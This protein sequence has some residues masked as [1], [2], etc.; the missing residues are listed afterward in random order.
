M[1]VVDVI[2]HYQRSI[3]KCQGNH[4][5]MLHCISK[6]YRLPVTV[7]HLQDTGIG[8]T[9]NN[10]RKYEGDT[11]EAAKALVAKW[12]AMVA[13]EDSSEGEEQEEE[14]HQN[15][16]E[17]EDTSLK[18]DDHRSS[19]K[20][21]YNDKE[22]SQYKE[23]THDDR[24]RSHHERDRSHHTE[25]SQH[26]EKSHHDRDRSHYEKEKSH[27]SKK[28]ID[29]RSKK[30]SS[31]EQSR[32]RKHEEENGKKYEKRRHKQMTESESSESEENSTV[33]EEDG[34]E[35]D[36]EVHST[37]QASLNIDDNS[38]EEEPEPPK[39]KNHISTKEHSRSHSSSSSSNNKEHSSNKEHRNSK[40]HGNNKQQNSHRQDKDRSKHKT[41]ISDR[42][43][44]KRKEES[45]KKQKLSSD[46]PE[47]KQPTVKI[48]K[49]KT[50]NEDDM[51][52]KQHISSSSPSTSS[53]S[54]SSKS[55]S[56]TKKKDVSA[57][58]SPKEHCSEAT[59]TAVLC[60]QKHRSMS[61]QEGSIKCRKQNCLSQEEHFMNACIKQSSETQISN[62]IESLDDDMRY[63]PSKSTRRRDSFA[64]YGKQLESDFVVSASVAL[65]TLQTDLKKY[66]FI[67]VLSGSN[68]YF[69]NNSMR[70][71]DMKLEPLDVDLD[72]TLPPITPNYKP[73]P[74]YNLLD[75]P[76]HRKVKQL[77]EEEALSRVMSTKNQRTKVYSGV[78]SGKSW[79]TVPSL[80]DIC[81]RVLQE[82]IDALEYTGGVPYELLK[83]VL[84]HATPEQLFM[85]EHHNPYLI[86]DT[87]E[88]WK[89]HCQKQ[90]RTKQRQDME[91]S[92]EMYLRCLDE[93]EAKLKALTSNIQQSI[94]KSTPVR[95]TKL[96]Y[97]DSVAKP[98]R[99]VARQQAKFGTAN[100]VS[101]PS[102][103]PKAT[104]KANALAAS[105]SA[106]ATPVPAP[107]TISTVTKQKPRMAP[108]MQKTMKL[109]KSFKR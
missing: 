43:N 57:K 70:T 25:R 10:L 46:I 18:Q 48:K 8:R 7:Q 47:K 29:E 21:K 109:V 54:R 41:E 86:D 49:E 55:S 80:Y 68:T 97:V 16:V 22:K 19:S 94:A 73:L 33:A 27:H 60:L 24:D 88:L 87:D 44:D 5:R 34:S 74:H 85:L 91:T 4:E 9:V 92:R 107:R 98:P 30:S 71:T 14:N 75:S 38:S 66:N 65:L 28:H 50:D 81:V 102:A 61:T 104:V 39:Q 31:H 82:N 2:K 99:N 83:P 62:E 84:Q 90:F 95:Q 45:S 1:S 108:L 77:S 52:K 63:A 20:R 42:K 78:K 100:K 72:A 79:A 103:A 15:S 12:K 101:K 23:K 105:I 59:H 37:S 56:A 58:T 11:G 3:E 6:L 69:Q 93:R 106:T 53:T 96:A 13:A 17:E 51:R 67:V 32:K 76:P 64:A 35:N 26:R 89:F 40:E 36:S